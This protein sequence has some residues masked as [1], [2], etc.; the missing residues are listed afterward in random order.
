MVKEWYLKE[1]QEE[2]FYPHPKF[3]FENLVH[4]HKDRFGICKYLKDHDIPLG[5]LLCWPEKGGGALSDL[6]IIRHMLAGNIVIHPFNPNQL[7]PNSYDVTVGHYYY[8]WRE[9]NRDRSFK[10]PIRPTRSGL[11]PDIGHDSQAE[12]CAIAPTP[13]VPSLPIYNPFDKDHVQYFWQL[14]EAEKKH[15]LEYELDIRLEGVEDGDE[16]ILL[17]PHEM[18][19]GHT[20]EFVGGLNVIIPEISGKSSTGRNMTEMCSDANMGNIGFLNRYTLEI[21]NKSGYAIPLVVEKVAYASFT[22]REAQVPGQNYKSQYASS[23]DIEEVVKAWEPQM[24]L[25]R[26]KRLEERGDE[27]E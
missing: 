2:N 12:K 22:F 11:I 5:A 9:A 21:A 13:H 24:M 27:N 15:Q 6:G 17:L 23:V 20:N 25:P 16:V 3:L 19:L 10:P 4:H 1:F 18:I 14:K 26:M 8:H 7:G